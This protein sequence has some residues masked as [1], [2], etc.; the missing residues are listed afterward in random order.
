MGEKLK[1]GIESIIAVVILVGLVIAL[2]IA[3]VLPI[4]QEGKTIGEK[5]TDRLS[6]LG[7]KLDN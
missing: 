2:I 4:A 7:D 3:T 1:G 5:G 6:E